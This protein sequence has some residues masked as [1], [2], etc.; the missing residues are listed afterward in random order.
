MI[1]KDVE[2]WSEEFEGIEARVCKNRS[3]LGD[4]SRFPIVKYKTKALATLFDVG[5]VSAHREQL[6]Q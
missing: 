3:L 6:E 5:P 2:K 4:G 1:V